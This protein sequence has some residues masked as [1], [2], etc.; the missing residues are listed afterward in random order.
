MKT[1]RMGLLTNF[2]TNDPASTFHSHYSSFTRRE[3]VLGLLALRAS[4]EM[5][6][7]NSELVLQNCYIMEQNQRLKKAAELLHKER[8]RLLSELKA[9]QRQPAT[10]G[11]GHGDHEDD[12]KPA[13]SASSDGCGRSSLPTH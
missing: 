13:S 12:D 7:V 5:E 3:E 10:H 2:Q 1:I 6:K 4:K 8:Q 11:H 9:Q